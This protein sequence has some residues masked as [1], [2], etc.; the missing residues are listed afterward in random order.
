M[1]RC[2]VRK[3]EGVFRGESAF[4]A[5]YKRDGAAIRKGC[6]GCVRWMSGSDKALRG[7]TFVGG[8]KADV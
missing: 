4:G 5:V 3:Q 6:A 1:W 2:R 8:T 7:Y